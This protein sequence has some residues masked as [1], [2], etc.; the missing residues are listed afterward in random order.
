VPW[1]ASTKYATWQQAAPKEQSRPSGEPG[2]DPHHTAH[3]T[4]REGHPDH[5]GPPYLPP[6]HEPYPAEQQRRAQVFHEDGD[7]DRDPGD[8]QVVQRLD[9]RDT[10]QP[11]PD[12]QPG[13]LERQSAVTQGDGQQYQ[14]GARH[15]QPHHVQ[16]I[17]SGLDERLRRDPG[18]A[19][20]HSGHQGEPQPTTPHLS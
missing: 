4:D 8:R 3:P 12:H 1:S 10:E 14:R 11:E 9:A 18:T 2:P 13:P 6:L 19:E 16:R 17:E 7:T 15:S 20:G 5:G